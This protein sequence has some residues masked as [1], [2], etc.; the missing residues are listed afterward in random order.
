[1]TMQE[2]IAAMQTKRQPMERVW[3]DGDGVWRNRYEYH[4][5]YADRVGAETAARFAEEWGDRA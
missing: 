4:A 5:R 2:K 3:E 1:M